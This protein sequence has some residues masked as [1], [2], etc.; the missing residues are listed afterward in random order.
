[1]T[2]SHSKAKLNVDKVVISGESGGGNLSIATTMKAVKEGKHSLVQGCFSLCP[3]IAGPLS[4]SGPEI[5]EHPSLIENEGLFLSLKD[6]TLAKMY[7]FSTGEA[8]RTPPH[9]QPKICSR[10]MLGSE[11]SIIVLSGRHPAT[12]CLC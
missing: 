5:G 11:H 6:P 8:G 3:Y 10:T 2:S 4:Y 1:M 12:V 9:W 7:T